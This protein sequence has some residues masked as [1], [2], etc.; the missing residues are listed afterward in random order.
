MTIAVRF[1]PASAAAAL[2]EELGGRGLALATFDGGAIADGP[3]LLAALG[4]ALDF[5]P[6]YGRNW[7]AAEECLRDL[8]ERYPQGC[9]LFI[10]RAGT[11]WQR[12]P[13]KMGMLTSLWLA[14]SDSLAADGIP[15]RLIFLLEDDR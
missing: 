5:P 10:D 2:L 15:L 7:D 13:R 11:L 6:Y 9:A 4:K 14:A 8:G 12:L 1:A 3:D